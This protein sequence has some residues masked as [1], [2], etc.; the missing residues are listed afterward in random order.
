MSETPKKPAKSGPPP[1]KPVPRAKPKDQDDDEPQAMSRQR[2]VP[3]KR[4]SEE[5]EDAPKPAKRFPPKYAFLLAGLFVIVA[6][7]AYFQLAQIE[8]QGGRAQVHAV[9]AGLYNLGGIW[10]PVGF[11]GFLGILCAVIGVLEVLKKP[12]EDDA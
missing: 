10:L 5:E 8:A 2:A 4:R 11:F 12:P 6:V 1:L 7:I 9:I 3:R